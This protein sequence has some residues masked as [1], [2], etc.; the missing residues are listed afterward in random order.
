[1]AASTRPRRPLRR[2]RAS[3]SI[4]RDD[5]ELV[6]VEGGVAAEVD[7]RRSSGR[8]DGERPR[9]RPGRSA[10]LNTKRSMIER[11][12]ER[13]EPEEQALAPQRGVAG[14]QPGEHRR[15]RRRRP[16]RAARAAERE[17]LPRRCRCRARCRAGGEER[18]EPG[19]RRLAEGEVAGEPGDAHDRHEDHGEGEH[20]VGEAQV[21]AAEEGRAPGPRRP[22]RR[23][24]RPRRSGWCAWP[25]ERAD[26]ARPACDVSPTSSSRRTCTSTTN[27]TM[28]DRFRT[29]GLVE[30]R[31]QCCR[32]RTARSCRAGSRPRP[33]TR[34]PKRIAFGTLVR[35]ATTA[36]ENVSMPKK[37]IRVGSSTPCGMIRPGDRGERAAE[38]PRHL[39]HAVGVDGGQLGQLAPVDHGSDRR[40]EERAPEQHVEQRRRRRAR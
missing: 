35:R 14:R 21:G 22:R 31:R 17:Q 23:R 38:R 40:A 19:D 11:E 33:I 26:E 16:S 30:A 8:V 9:R 28:L 7:A 2:L 32:R 20:R 15:R 39:R 25:T 29:N 12:A 37:M 18:A 3:T 34:K 10:V 1:M 13:G 27:S 6:E 36:T 4:E 5:D 24:R